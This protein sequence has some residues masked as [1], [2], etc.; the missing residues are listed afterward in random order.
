MIIVFT[1]PILINTYITFST[2]KQGAFHEEIEDSFILICFSIFMVSM[3]IDT[4]ILLI[5]KC[6]THTSFL[7]YISTLFPEN[8]I[9]K[10][11]QKIMLSLLLFYYGLGENEHSHPVNSAVFYLCTIFDLQHSI[12]K[13]D[14]FIF[15]YFSLWSIRERTRSP[16]TLDYAAMLYLR[17]I[18][19]LYCNSF[20]EK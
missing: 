12:Y 8:Y 5:M 11:K 1:V 10:N 18:S 9:C 20:P 19:N 17:V 2:F 13:K 15:H 16:C 6:F 4:I 7:T 3:R 14:Q